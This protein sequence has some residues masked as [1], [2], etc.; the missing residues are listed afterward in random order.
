MDYSHIE[1]IKE[2]VSF[3]SNPFCIFSMCPAILGR[4]KDLWESEVYRFAKLKRLKVISKYVP[5]GD[6][7]L[8]KAIYEMILNEYLQTDLE[9][10]IYMYM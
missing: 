8:S 2:H 3:L 5:R 6:L 10:C 9:V 4:N 7:R 1:K